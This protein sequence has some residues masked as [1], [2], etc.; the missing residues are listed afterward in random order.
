MSVPGQS[1][2]FSFTLQ[3][4]QLVDDIEFQVDQFNWWRTRA[5]SI[6]LGIVQNQDVFPQ[7]TGGPLSLPEPIKPGNMPGAMSNSSPAFRMSLV[8]CSTP[9][10]V[11]SRPMRIRSMTPSSAG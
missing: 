2:V 11:T 7:E 6:G 8:F 10:L 5:P 1:G 4:Q 3:S 9:R